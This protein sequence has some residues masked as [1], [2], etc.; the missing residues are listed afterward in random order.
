MEAEDAPDKRANN[1]LVVRD[2]SGV[3][4]DD[5]QYPLRRRVGYRIGL[6]CTLLLS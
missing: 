5:V 2:A 6:E 1:G 4:L 3:E